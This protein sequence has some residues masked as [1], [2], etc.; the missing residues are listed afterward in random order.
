[1]HTPLHRQVS[2]LKQDL[3]STK[4]ALQE[5]T[6][7]TEALEREAEQLRAALDATRTA[8]AEQQALNEEALATRDTLLRTMQAQAA[9]AAEAHAALQ[10]RVQEAE[11]A[12]EEA[13]QAMTEHEVSALR[14]QLETAESSL[15]GRKMRSMQAEL[16]ALQKQ[17]KQHEAESEALARELDAARAAR[18]A[19]GEQVAYLTEQVRAK[20]EE[21]VQ[22]RQVCVC[23][24]SC[25]YRADFLMDGLAAPCVQA[26]L[27]EA[28]DA[29]AMPVAEYEAGT[30]LQELVAHMQSQ[31]EQ[32]EQA[33][34]QLEVGAVVFM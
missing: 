19:L 27:P 13:L 24:T 20:E 15:T 25:V 9:E 2:L 30:G 3:A 34:R 8:A 1:M 21:L 29:P 32:G 4:T 10:A 31:L 17:V 14:E 23:I 16:A 18:S 5:S 11:A 26:V 6:A 12:R 7:A 28:G 22:L 33:R